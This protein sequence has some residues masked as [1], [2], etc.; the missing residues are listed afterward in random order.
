MKIGCKCNEISTHLFVG[1]E[2]MS[3]KVNDIFVL[4]WRL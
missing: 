4:N 3:V 2:E 1:F